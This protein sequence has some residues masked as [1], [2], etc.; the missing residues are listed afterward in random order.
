MGWDSFLWLVCQTYRGGAFFPSQIS[1][2]T[3]YQ[4]VASQQRKD[5]A[6]DVAQESSFLGEFF[7]RDDAISF[8]LDEV[9][10]VE[11]PVGIWPSS[12]LRV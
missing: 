9:F 7:E 8:S 4:K 1:V 10:R 6:T 11:G 3:W 12:F 5:L 2:H